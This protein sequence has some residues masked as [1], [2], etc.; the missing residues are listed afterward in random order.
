MNNL[1]IV[2]KTQSRSETIALLNDKARMGRDK[3]S[4]T[5]FTTNLLATLNPDRND[6]DL[7]A[8]AKIIAAMRT[9]TFG[10]DSPER[11]IAWFDVDG[12][13]VMMKIDYYD[14]TLEWGSEDP[15]N[16]AVTRR[17]ITLM[18]PADY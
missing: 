1:N 12:H 7:Q 6:L 15:A 5:M 3:T 13:R 10:N 4:K 9:C 8:Q 14:L 16:P 2:S 11:D 17:V 18:L